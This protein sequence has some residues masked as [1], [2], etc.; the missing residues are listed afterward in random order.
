MPTETDP[1]ETDP[2][3]IGPAGAG[4]PRLV[5]DRPARMRCGSSPARALVIT[6]RE[7]PTADLVVDELNRRGVPLVRFD[8]GDL[9]TEVSLNA[10]L[11]P[12][13]GR[14][15]GSVRHG[16]R[17]APLDAIEA[18]YYRRPSEFRA[19]PRLSDP[20]RT[21]AVAQARHALS[22]VLS[23]LPGVLWL[24]HPSAMADARVKPYQLSVAA[25]CGLAVA[26]S[27]LTTIPEAV[28]AF[29]HASG[30]RI[31]TKPLAASTI[32]EQGRH[33][34]AYTAEVP[35]EQWAHPSVATTPHLFQ[36]RLDG[37]DVRMTMVGD[38][39]FAAIIVPHDPT[40]PVD[41]RAH[42]DH[43]DYT[44]TEIPAA[45]RRACRDLLDDLGLVFGAFDFR[46]HDDL[47]D[48]DDAHDTQEGWTFLELNPNGQWAFVPQLRGPITSAI[49]DL[50]ES[51][52][53]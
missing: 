52:H 22:G 43:V 1:T 33:G 9:P 4:A 29:A 23:A 18:I 35:H 38:A 3:D 16:G 30:G 39:A 40:G 19:D 34:V 24:N 10:N 8:A 12:H 45:V 37:R 26:P 13:T 46:V 41:I 42:H 20:E 27:L 44:V 21:F 51:P 48:P 28:P 5:P 36:P 17:E 49:A 11:S 32:T 53:R 15:D 7:D 2:T 47:T 50:L 14:W 25:R 31:I 6:Q